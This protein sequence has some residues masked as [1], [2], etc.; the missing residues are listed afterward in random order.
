MYLI[1]NYIKL[2]LNYLYRG[3]YMNKKNLNISLQPL[4]EEDKEQFIFD[5]Q[6]AFNYHIA[7][8][9]DMPPGVK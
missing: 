1:L 5:N 3:N 9:L 2:Y 6:E 4:E 7:K 8:A